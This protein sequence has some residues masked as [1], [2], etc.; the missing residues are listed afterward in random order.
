MGEHRYDTSWMTPDDFRVPIEQ[1]TFTFQSPTFTFAP[2]KQSAEE[3]FDTVNRPEHYVGTN[4]ME[5]IDVIEAFGLDKDFCLANA[6]K[7]ILRH[8][9]KNGVED[10]KKAVWYLNRAI[11]RYERVHSGS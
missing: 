8:A 10:L 11:S 2:E 6:C 3:N 5:C 7:Y 4:G 1:Q 9:R